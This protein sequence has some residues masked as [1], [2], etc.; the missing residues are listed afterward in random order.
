MRARRAAVM[1]LL[2]AVSAAAHAVPTFNE[3]KAGF[4]P[5]DVTLLDRRGVPVQT[6]RV[7][8]T[9]RRLDWVPL[10][11][12]SPALLQ[13]IVLSE[14]RRFYEHSGVDPHRLHRHAA[15]VEQGHVGRL[16]RRLHLS[17]IHI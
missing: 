17:L 6:V 7:D 10:Q 11:S 15:A 8:R 4:K 13:A 12:M 5:S 14:D 9:V 2:A 16:E 3:V 1:V